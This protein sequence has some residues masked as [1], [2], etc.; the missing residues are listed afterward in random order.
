LHRQLVHLFD[1]VRTQAQK[2]EEKAS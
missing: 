2:E 1:V